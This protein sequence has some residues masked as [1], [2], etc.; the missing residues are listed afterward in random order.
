MAYLKGNCTIQ[1]QGDP[2]LVLERLW[3]LL[4][5]VQGLGIHTIDGRHR[6][7]PQ[8]LGRAIEADPASFDGEP[9]Q[10]LQRGARCAA[11]QLQISGA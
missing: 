4:R 3:L 1:G 5:R 9:L 2:K 6:A 7:G 10:T 11:D 8:R